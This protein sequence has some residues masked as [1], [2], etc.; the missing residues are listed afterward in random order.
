MCVS[1]PEINQTFKLSRAG[2]LHKPLSHTLLPVESKRSFQ[3]VHN[4]S[5]RIEFQIEF[6]PNP[7]S[8]WCGGGEYVYACEIEYI[9]RS[10]FRVIQL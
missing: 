7:H 3:K 4:V 6:L 5:M 9:L 8:F 2:I 10:L 1:R